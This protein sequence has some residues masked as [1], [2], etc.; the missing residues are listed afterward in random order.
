MA[1][2]HVS[3]TIA[4]LNAMIARVDEA[5]APNLA[6]LSAAIGEYLRDS[7]QQRFA[8]QA[9]PDGDPWEPLKPRTIARKRQNKDKI[10]TMRG[11]LRR[12]IAYRVLSPGRVEVGSPLIYAAAH[13]FSWKPG[14]E[15]GGI[16]ARPFLGINTADETE[17]LSIAEDW[18]A[19]EL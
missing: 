13:Q 19:G 17:I 6:S 8:D 1:G 11:Y 15:G 18:A 14:G 10:L 16:P 3:A 2:A 12:S 4:G 5:Q 7:T 9:D